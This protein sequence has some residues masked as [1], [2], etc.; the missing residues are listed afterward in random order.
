MAHDFYFPSA[1]EWYIEPY[2][3]D[4][5]DLMTKLIDTLNGMKK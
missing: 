1:Q 2:E 3:E 5:R 4:K